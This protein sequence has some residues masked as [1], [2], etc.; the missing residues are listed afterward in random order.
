MPPHQDLENAIP[1][2]QQQAS[3]ASSGP[4]AL[5]AATTGSATST[6]NNMEIIKGSLLNYSNTGK[7]K[8]TGGEKRKALG[9]ITNKSSSTTN[10]NPHQPAPKKVKPNT[11]IQVFN[12]SQP[13]QQTEILPQKL[14]SS[15]SNN[16]TRNIL[17][18]KPSSI[19]KPQIKLFE[20]VNDIEYCPEPY[21]LPEYPTPVYTEINPLTG[22]AEDLFITLPDEKLKELVKLPSKDGS[23]LSF[24][25]SEEIPTSSSNDVVPPSP[26]MTPIILP[27]DLFNFDFL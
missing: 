2:L 1:F 4:M 16:K 18:Q 14:Q 26:H 9:D 23:F 25:L 22:K 6:T 15:S 10:T 24:N 12:D 19:P 17:K 21:E 20:D 3:N 11:S 13:T 8:G 7:S 5:K 27:D